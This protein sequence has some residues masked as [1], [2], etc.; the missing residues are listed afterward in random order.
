MFYYH[1]TNISYI[2]VQDTFRAY[3]FFN[4][5]NACPGPNA[6]MTFN[7]VRTAHRNKN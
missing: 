2:E 7:P 3:A 6:Q 1:D 5:Y 4:L